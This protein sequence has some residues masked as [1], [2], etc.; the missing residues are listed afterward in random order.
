[1]TQT[2]GG[3]T[4][5]EI[6]VVLSIIGVL[7]GILSVSFDSSREATRDAERKTD[8]TQL[9]LALEVYKSQNGRYPAQGCGAGG[10]A[11]FGTHT[12]VDKT[13]CGGTP[14]IN[15]LVPNYID[16]LPQD[17]RSE[18]DD[19]AGFMYQTDATGSIYKIVIMSSIE[20]RTIDSYDEKFARCPYDC[21]V[22]WCDATGPEATTYAL[23]SRGAECL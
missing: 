3:F 12:D 2:R 8:L 1:M 5:I 15:G 9:Q 19:N 10:W 16:A 7:L 11:G 6:L 4:L 22:A 17:P 13:N 18:D 14:W 21:G 23:Y 20:N